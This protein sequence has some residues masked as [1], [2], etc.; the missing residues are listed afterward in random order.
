[1][2]A[3]A[4]AASGTPAEEGTHPGHVQTPPPLGAL[5]HSRGHFMLQKCF[6]SERKLGEIRSDLVPL[7][8]LFIDRI[9]SVFYQ[10]RPIFRVNGVE[11]FYPPDW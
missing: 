5:A 10:E 1:M 8:E 11:L 2:L 6:P 3:T 4:E 9:I 7:S